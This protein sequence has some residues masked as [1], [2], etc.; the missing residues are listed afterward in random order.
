MRT[1][2]FITFEGID[3]CGK[4]T[5]TERAAAFLDA[6]GIS[7]IRTR[8]PGGTPIAET[9]RG[10][11]LDPANTAMADRC[12][13]LLY[14]AARAQHVAEKIMPALAAGIWVLCDRF[15]DATLAYQGAG[16]G[17]DGALLSPLLTFAAH[18]IAPDCTF[19]F[20]VDTATAA[21]RMAAAGRGP[22]RME[23]NPRDFHDRVRSGYQA[24]AAAEPQ[25]VVLID[26][27]R[28]AATIAQAVAARLGAL[29]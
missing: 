12:E 16:R 28:D 24:I 29:V 19:V 7:Y 1:G 26:A 5:Q 23:K 9:I 8:E 27:S 17:L 10:L 6:Q 14:L 3:G 13:L 25:R 2:K 15:A 20:D 4:S 22:D 21:G 11:I 18:G